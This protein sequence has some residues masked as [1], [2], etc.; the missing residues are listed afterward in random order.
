[1]SFVHIFFALFFVFS[2]LY[3][4]DGRKDHVTLMLL[5]NCRLLKEELEKSHL[6][7]LFKPG[8]WTELFSF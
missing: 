5:Q 4:N 1:M 7:R 6:L 3:E 8:N 2:L